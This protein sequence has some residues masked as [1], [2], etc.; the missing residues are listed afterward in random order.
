RS[1]AAAP[2]RD[3]R[4]H[5]RQ[6][7]R[8]AGHAH[9]DL[10][11]RPQRRRRERRGPRQPLLARRHRTGDQR[12][13]ARPAHQRR[14]ARPARPE[15]AVTATPNLEPPSAAECRASRWFT[16]VFLATVLAGLAFAAALAWYTD[17][18]RTFGTGHAGS[19]LTVEFDLKPQAFLQLDPPP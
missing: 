2:A 11:R 13:A 19:F 8:R 7:R 16:R 1:G 14:G 6:R 4:Q 12:P 18:L 17:P 5:V 15:P 10:A 9:G 3:P